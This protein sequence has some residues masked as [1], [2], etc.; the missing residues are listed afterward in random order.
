MEVQIWFQC[1]MRRRPFL[2]CFMEPLPI[3]FRPT[4]LNHLPSVWIEVIS[5][6][7]LTSGVKIMFQFQLFPM[8]I[9][10]SVT[11]FEL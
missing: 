1:Y 8:M 6:Q 3:A 10:A 2:N 7:P 4:T 11:G 5:K 9:C